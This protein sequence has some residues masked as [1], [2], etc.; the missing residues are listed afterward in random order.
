[1]RTQTVRPARS[2]DLRRSIE[3]LDALPVRPASSR[4]VLDRI[5][6]TPEHDGEVEPASFPQESQAART[7]APTELDPGWALASSRSP[8]PPSSALNLAFVAELSWW[9][10][11]EGVA[12]EGI[13]VLWRN[14]VATALAARRLAKEAGDPDPQRV[15]R[16][17]LLSRLGLWAWAAVEPKT[18]AEWIAETEGPRRRLIERDRLGGDHS[19]IGLRLAERLGCDPLV[20]EACWLGEQPGTVLLDASREAVRMAWIREARTL[21]DRT[22][23]SLATDHTSALGSTEPRLRLLIAEVQARC[24]APFVDPSAS[25]REERL[26]RDNAHLRL[27]VGGLREVGRRQK[28]FLDAFAASRPGIDPDSWGEKAALAWCD[29]PGIAAARVVWLDS[30]DVTP[31]A[32]SSPRPASLVIPLSDGHRT[33]AEIQLWSDGG[34]PGLSLDGHASL[35]A[36]NA[37][38]VGISSRLRSMGR[39]ESTLNV[40]RGGVDQFEPELRGSKLEALAEFAAGAGHELNNP[41]AVIVGR[42]KSD[43]AI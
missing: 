16:A 43:G 25:P 37:W 5:S 18:L 7:V 24:S 33:L 35:P 9:S 15:A 22:P 17:A 2:T 39:L 41:L 42:R 12:S 31:E 3:R 6:E 21:A 14:S 34:T 32:S 11:C 30:G 26:T 36:W 4:F 40:I 27:Q 19:S 23:W 29:E 20:V 8:Q 13:S 10:G 1:M 28:G 38:A